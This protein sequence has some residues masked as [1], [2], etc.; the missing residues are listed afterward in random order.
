MENN[1]PNV[2]DKF[3][4]ALCEKEVDSLCN[5]HIFPE[6][7]Y[8]YAYDDKH[9]AHG[10]H[11]RG[12]KY[13]QNG[14]KEKMLCNKCEGILSKYE[15]YFKEDFFSKNTFPDVIV[16]E[17]VAVSVDDPLTFKLF[18]LANLFR[19]SVS[20]DPTFKDV[21]L[22]SHLPVIRDMLINGVDNNNYCVFGA[23]IYNEDRK[24]VKG[25][26]LP[27]ARKKYEG[28]LLYESVYAGCVWYI[29]VSSHNS[30]TLNEMSF[31]SPGIYEMPADTMN[32]ISQLY[33]AK[34]LLKK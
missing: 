23:V 17:S 13:L 18:H 24:A 31:K 28:H 30:R 7:L 25:L 6:F 22:G 19:A 5:S 10:I 34:E 1:I 3:K 12:I 14:F 2:E 29:K 8:A 26:I 32:D 27:H 15:K 4:C 33:H 9:R 16:G 20:K 11:G 21:D